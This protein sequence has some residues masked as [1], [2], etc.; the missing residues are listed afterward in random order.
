MYVLH[1]LVGAIAV[2]FSFRPSK[3]LSQYHLGSN[4]LA[5]TSD[6]VGEPYKYCHCASSTNDSLL[7]LS[8]ASRDQ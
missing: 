3:R 2:T 6:D 8:S 4:I 7:S 1:L 5:L